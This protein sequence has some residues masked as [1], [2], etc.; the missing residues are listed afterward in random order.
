MDKEEMVYRRGY[1]QSVATTVRLLAGGAS[2]DDIKAW[3]R[4]L[5]HWRSGGKNRFPETE[6]TTRLRELYEQGDLP[7][8]GQLMS[9][10]G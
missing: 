1:H 5:R 8:R 6:M 4:I 3:E 9:D 7:E 10:D 2:I